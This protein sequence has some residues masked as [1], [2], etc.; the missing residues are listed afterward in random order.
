[1]CPRI[2]LVPLVAML[3][4]GTRVP[5]RALEGSARAREAF[6]LCQAAA[7]APESER[8]TML[9]RGLALA[10]EAVRIDERDPLAHFAV[11]CTLGRQLKQEGVGLGSLAA[12]RR[13]RREID[14][15]L[16]LDPAMV[17]ALVAKAAFLNQ[18]PSLLGGDPDEAKRLVQQA[19]ALDP[20]G[21]DRVAEVRALLTENDR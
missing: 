14:R 13:L 12:V 19:W 10:E 9:R 15:A 21:V 1:M 11:F 5:A 18:L 3:L 6:G 16:E 4:L 2:H 17:D 7:T 8:S 20:G